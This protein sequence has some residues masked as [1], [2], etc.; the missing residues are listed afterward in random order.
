V[1]ESQ[2]QK[3]AR[4]GL[5]STPTAAQEQLKGEGSSVPPQ[6]GLKDVL[7][8]LFPSRTRPKQDLSYKNPLSWESGTLMREETQQSDLLDIQEPQ[9]TESVAEVSY[10]QAECQ[11]PP[12]VAFRE[13]SPFRKL[14]INYLQ[15]VTPCFETDAKETAFLDALQTTFPSETLQFLNHHN[16]DATNVAEWAWILS[17]REVNLAVARYVALADDKLRAGRGR[18]PLWVPLQLLRAEHIGP[19]RLKDFIKGILSDLE[20]CLAKNEYRGWYWV[21]RVCLV[22]R[23]IRH[24]RQV[25]PECFRDISVIVRHLFSEYYS[26]QGQQ[27][28]IT[29][30]RRLAHIFNRFLGL[31]SLAPSK[32]PFNS[33]LAQQDA[34]LALLREMFAFKPPLPLAREGY[35]ALIAVQ[36]LHRKTGAERAWA[37]TKSQAWPPWRQIKSGIE[38]DLVYPGKESRVIK[39][40]RRMQEAGYALGDWEKA[41]GVLAGWDTDGSPTIQTRA[42]LTRQRMPWLLQAPERPGGEVRT[43]EAPGIWAARIR[44]T[45]TVRESW[46]S[47]CA[48]RV[49]LGDSAGSYEPYFAMLE[50]LLA[51]TARA[52]SVLQANYQAGDLKEVLED[53][54]DSRNLIYIEA[55]VPTVDEFYQ[56]MLFAGIKPAGSLIASLLKHSS[57]LEA[58]FEYI[59][60]CRWADVTK[61]VL[62]HGERYPFSRIRSTLEGIPLNTLAAFVFFLCKNAWTDKM[63]FLRLW[64]GDELGAPDANMQV[65]RF[66][67]LRYA[68]EMV[69]AARIRDVRVLNALLE[70]C[71]HGIRDHFANTSQTWLPRAYWRR[72]EAILWFDRSGLGISP[73]L[74]TFFYES[75]LLH[76][77]IRSEKTCFSHEEIASLAKATFVEAVYGR[78][79]GTFLPSPQHHLLTV[80]SVQDLMLLV[81]TL[82]AVRDSEGLVALV[83]WINEHAPK[84]GLVEQDE[85][86]GQ[87]VYGLDATEDENIQ[88]SHPLDKV[89][90]AIR[91]FLARLEDLSAVSMAGTEE[92]S[93]AL[94]ASGGVLASVQAEEN[95]RTLA[96]PSDEDLSE[97]TALHSRWVGEVKFVADMAARRTSRAEVHAT[98]IEATT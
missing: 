54:T 97:F 37:E 53:S 8:T 15:I 94:P 95:C 98:A 17:A 57:S 59:R 56:Q 38:E 60:A 70:G 65:E 90:C 69:D 75:N 19:T 35:R 27:V 96:W 7:S 45:R 63:Q 10:W 67:A 43:G 81:R 79:I 33:Y 14:A 30:L 92:G 6:R 66:T 74:G 61:D 49:S 31:L 42:R 85:K 68:V 9:H 62:E 40:L 44:A 13:T 76:L 71:W 50:R 52:G 2:V 55:A 36:L 39:L 83:Q 5:G 48:Y 64:D 87:Q 72:V 12:R 93:V 26:V 4:T 34:Q 46:A 11:E 24:A 47:F 80:P 25:A 18:I 32:S 91:V 77:L 1:G 82:A 89:L 20:H 21:T 84:Y 29:E 78:P 41:A 86:A 22:V 16:L 58:G 23:L 28:Q 88:H 3:F 51:D 73:D